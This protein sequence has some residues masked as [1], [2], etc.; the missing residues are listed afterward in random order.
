[1]PCKTG[2]PKA[3]WH[4]SLASIRSPDSLDLSAFTRSATGGPRNQPFNPAMM[5]GGAGVRLRDWRILI[6]KLARK[7]HED[8]AP[9]MLAA[10]NYPAHRTICAFRAFHLQELSELFVQVLKLAKECGLI[11]LGMICVDGTKI[12]ANASSQQGDE[13][14]SDAEGRARA[15]GTNRCAFCQ[16]QGGRCG[17]AERAGTR[18]PG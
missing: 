16:G 15:E 7:L 6:A 3:T 11:K 5:A 17:R 4:T 2:C 8:V 14:R 9:R 1:M 12:K 10:D 13:L 18:Y